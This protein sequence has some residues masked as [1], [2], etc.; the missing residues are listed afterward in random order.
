VEG[1]PK[2]AGWHELYR[3]AG[4]T[5]LA[6]VAPVNLICPSDEARRRI[7]SV[8]DL[9]FRGDPDRSQFGAI[10]E[11]GRGRDLIGS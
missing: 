11:I 8:A 6:K 7:K 9:G 4:G 5:K 1:F 2:S 3:E 10:E